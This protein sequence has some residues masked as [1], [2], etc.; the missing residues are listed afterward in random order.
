M[1][2]KSIYLLITYLFIF[3]CTSKNQRMHDFIDKYNEVMASN[4]SIATV[5]KSKATYKSDNEIDIE[6]VYRFTDDEMQASL[7]KQLAS[8]VFLNIIKAVP[9][10]KSLYNDGVNFDLKLLDNSGVELAQII[11]NNKSTKETPVVSDLNSMIGIINA[12]LPIKDPETGA[13][14]IKVGIEKSSEIIYTY[15]YPDDMLK[16]MNLVGAEKIIKQNLATNPLLKNLLTNNNVKEIDKIVVLIFDKNKKEVKRYGITKNELLAASNTTEPVIDGDE[17]VLQGLI[18]ELNK[19]L[20]ITDKNFGFQYSKCQLEDKTLINTY[21]VPDEYIQALDVLEQQGAIKKGLLGLELI[22][23]LVN[24]TDSSVEK[25]TAVY[26][27]KK[28][29]VLKKYTLTKKEYLSSKK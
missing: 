5:A 23:R 24:V 26:Q 17:M 18:K 13:S 12:K 14:L 1:K 9:N 2:K 25:V 7:M 3:S 21:I 6:V 28:G 29:K 15:E 20:P 8:D 11:L 19:K 27:N 4:Q 10:G 22:E 16:I